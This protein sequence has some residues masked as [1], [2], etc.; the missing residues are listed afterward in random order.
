MNSCCAQYYII[1]QETN[2]EILDLSTAECNKCSCDC[3]YLQFESLAPYMSKLSNVNTR[4]E[5][6]INL[7]AKLRQ[8]IVEVSRLFDVLTNSPQGSFSKAHYQIIKLYGDGS[9]YLKIP[10]YI[11]GTLELYTGEGY[12]INENSYADIDGYLVLNPC[13]SKETSC[14]C[15]SNCGQHQK[16]ILPAGWKG[17]LQA[18]AKF[19]EDCSISAVRMAIRD[20]IIELNSFG[21]AKETNA[22][23]L[24]VSR[25]FRAPYS[26]TSLI[27]ELKRQKTFKNQF[28]FA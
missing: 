23:G 6:H 12:K 21:D 24:P 2:C 18:K 17:C 5:D 7:E 3:G 4:E 14:G 27:D 11:K 1:P 15:T 13:S 9:R 16:T 8:Q 20:Y 22:Q 28:S 25:G 19:G 10:K 26:W